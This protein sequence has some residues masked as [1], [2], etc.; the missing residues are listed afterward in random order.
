MNGDAMSA[1]REAELRKRVCQICGAVGLEL[2]P[3]VL[4]RPAV[5]EC[6]RQDL[7][8]WD[9]QGWICE[10]DLQKYRSRHVQSLIETVKGKLT[11]LEREVLESIEETDILTTN[12]VQDAVGG[13]TLG[14]RLAD[15]IADFGGSW[16]FISIFGVF[17]FIWMIVNSFLLVMQPFD[18]YPY[19]LL[20]LVL[21]C[22]AAIQA[23]VIMMS[24][25][26]Q[27][28][29]DRLRAMHD[30]QI[31][32]KSELEVRHLHHKVDHLMSHQWEMLVEIQEVQRDFLD[33]LSSRTG[34]I[35]RL[36]REH[37]IYAD[38]AKTLTSTL[39]LSEV[40]RIIME[41]V[42]ELLAPKNW[43]LLLL[44]PDG[45]HLRFEL[46]VGEGSAALSGS[47][48]KVGEGIAGWVALNGE[49]ILVEDA[50]KDPRFCGRFDEMSNFETHSII[51]VPLKNRGKV[52]GVINL[53]NRLEQTPFTER[54]KRSLE[55]IAEYA[56]I[57]IS[58]ADL[59]R[60]ARLAS[61]ALTTHQKT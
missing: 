1:P 51:C 20:N 46:V 44:E 8:Q 33:A 7:G 9:E 52:L 24:Q 25:N 27:E 32:L 47:R 19:I 13:L 28:A 14:Q 30:Y 48:L 40:L 60:T 18:P 16:A 42:G 29:R 10:N 6:I 35:S 23:P 50:R 43:S 17:L 53:I 54:D 2:R 4:V 11:G 5:G 39:D 57:A 41:K 37:E 21:S 26:R 58:N 45:E 12:P 22:L 59:Y 49:S 56:A 15:R 34:K 55:A 31:N 61:E 38:L 3:G 36:R